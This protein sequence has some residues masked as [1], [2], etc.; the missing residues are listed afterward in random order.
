MCRPRDHD[1]RDAT[2]LRFSH[3]TFALVRDS[4]FSH[5]LKSQNL[6]SLSN[7]GATLLRVLSLCSL[8]LLLQD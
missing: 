1:G 8:L 3:P 5:P 2:H 4:S 7:A 6:Q